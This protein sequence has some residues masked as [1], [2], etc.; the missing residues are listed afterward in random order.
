M[1]CFP[2]R[3]RLTALVTA[4]VQWPVTSDNERST[5]LTNQ[6]IFAAA[7][8]HIDA[9]VADR[10]SKARNWRFTY[11]KL[12]STPPHSLTRTHYPLITSRF[13]RCFPPFCSRQSGTCWRT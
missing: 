1:P 12:R 5:T 11:D 8:E 13:S 6:R 7:T 2:P 10:I 4:G 3:L 9:S